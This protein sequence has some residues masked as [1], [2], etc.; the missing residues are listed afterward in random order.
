MLIGVG[1]AGIA[2]FAIYEGKLE[3]PVFN[4]GLLKHNTVFRFSNLAALA[5]YCSTAAVAF[6][7]SLYLQYIKGFT[8]EHAGLILVTQPILM[9]VCS[10]IAGTLSDRIEP[11]VIASMGMAL[12]TLGLVL[13]TFLNSDSSLIY[14]VVSL[15]VLGLGFGF[16]SSPNTNAVMSSVDKRFYGVASSVLGTMRLTGQMFSMGL[17]M[18]LFALYIGGRKITPDTYDLFLQSMKTAFIIA[19]CLCFLGI[20]A[21]IARG[22]VHHPAGDKLDG[23]DAQP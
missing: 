23:R 18:L 11:G 5:N 2:V 20:F 16:F 17:T 6:L 15:M 8:A 9:I 21:S 10:P 4:V 19:A 3:F 22:R 13:L 14:V 1:I 7:L 12:T